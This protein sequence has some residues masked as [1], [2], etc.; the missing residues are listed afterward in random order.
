[1]SYNK[2]FEEVMDNINNIAFS[3]GFKNGL[4]WAH[5]AHFRQEISQEQYV[6]YEN[7]HNLRAKLFTENA[8]D[9]DVSYDTYQEALEFEN[10]FKNSRT[11][12]YGGSPIKKRGNSGNPSLSPFGEEI[13]SELKKMRKFSKVTYDDLVEAAYRIVKAFP[14]RSFK[15]TRAR[16]GFYE[17]VGLFNMDNARRELAEKIVASLEE[18]ELAILMK[19]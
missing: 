2:E 11:R 6:R 10:I 1:M 14:P 4:D 15:F 5:E 3:E 12:I 8:K 17:K 18:K 9:I 19:E 16:Y 7:I 13:Q